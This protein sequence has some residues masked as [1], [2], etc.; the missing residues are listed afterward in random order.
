MVLLKNNVNQIMFL[1][2]FRCIPPHLAFKPLSETFKALS[3]LV[4]VYFSY[5]SHFIVS[6]YYTLIHLLI[7]LTLT[8][9]FSSSGPSHLLCQNALPTSFTFHPFSFTCLV[10]SH[11]L[12]L[13][14]HLVSEAIPEQAN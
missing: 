12:T 14:Y 6:L 3:Y 11:L 8:H 10:I 9:A 13:Q 5:L 4:S 2:C 7:S 1:L